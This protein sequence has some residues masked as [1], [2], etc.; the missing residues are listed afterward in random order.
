MS[1]RK[2]ER[3]IV[4]GIKII[5][6]ILLIITVLGF[7]I[8]FLTAY[9]TGEVTSFV[10]WFASWLADNIVFAVYILIITAFIGL[11]SPRI[12]RALRNMSGF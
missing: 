9:R 2:I 6:S 8:A 12:A 4:K 10:E 7:T 5:A 3:D 11:I 1:L